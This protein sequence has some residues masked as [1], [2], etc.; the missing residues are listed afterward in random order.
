MIEVLGDVKVPS[1]WRSAVMQMK[2]IFLLVAFL[3]PIV[4]Q[5]SEAQTTDPCTENGRL[6]GSFMNARQFGVPKSSL[7]QLINEEEKD[8][9]ARSGLKKIVDKLYSHPIYPTR[10]QKE[11]AVRDFAENSFMQCVSEHFPAT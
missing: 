6:M 2:V 9:K 1:F 5:A 4:C 7:Y 11:K 10:Q 8:Q 3:V